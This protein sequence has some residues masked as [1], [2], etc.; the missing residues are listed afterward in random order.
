MEFTDENFGTEQ[1]AFYGELTVDINDQWQVTGGIRYSAWESYSEFSFGRFGDVFFVG[2]DLEGT[3]PGDVAGL[4]VEEYG[5]EDPASRDPSNDVTIGKLNVAYQPGDDLLVFAQWSEGFRLVELG[6]N[7]IE[8][9]ACL[10]GGS[11]EIPGLNGQNLN[12]VQFSD[13]LTNIELG[14]KKSFADG[15]VTAN[16]GAYMIDWKNIQ[17]EG[18]LPNNCGGV[19]PNGDAGIKGLEFEVSALLSDGWRLNIAGA[20]TDGEITRVPQLVREDNT[21][22]PLNLADPTG[23]QNGTRMPG[24][25]RTQF[26]VTTDY[27]W[28]GLVGGFDGNLNVNYVYTDA[29]NNNQNESNVPG[30]R[31]SLIE[32][33]DIS[34]LNLGFT[35]E[36]ESLSFDFY[37][38]NVFDSI[39]SAFSTINRAETRL[40]YNIARPRVIGV[41]VRKEF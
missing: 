1:E 32:G 37:V 40:Q 27:T 19:L 12:P 3:A 35:L 34:L 39:Q 21:L 24:T 9:P 13:D 41:G 18:E 15:R 8:D 16:V 36:K 10:T 22:I 17:F 23:A 33:D 2:G 11:D 4:D 30:L 5:S 28:P 7:E 6:V 25:P 20:V 29:V 38:N 26:S 14:V 31:G